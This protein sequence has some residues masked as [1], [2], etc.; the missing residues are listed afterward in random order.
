MRFALP[1]PLL[2]LLLVPRAQTVW[3]GRL[4]PKQLLGPWYVLAVASREKGFAQ[5]KVLRSVEGVVVSLTAENKLKMLASRSGQEGC[6][7]TVVELLK[8]GSGWV[9]ENPSLGVLEYRVLGT[10]FKDYAIVFTQLEFG[11][12]TFN[13]V[14]LYSRTKVASPEATKLFSKWSRDLGYLA[15]QQAKLQEDFTCAH[16][17]L[18][19][20]CPWGPGSGP[21]VSAMTVLGEEMAPKDVSML[22][23]STCDDVITGVVQSELTLTP[24]GVPDQITPNYRRESERDHIADFG[25]RGV[26][27]P[28]E[29]GET[30]KQPPRPKRTQPYPSSLTGTL[31]QRAERKVCCD[32][33]CS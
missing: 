5:G 2:V 31:C 14:E 4:D 17:V 21:V 15:Q 26:V 24:P 33:R 16:K 1:V 27:S 10:N 30:R 29:L 25:D 23:P 7:L 22:V 11:D 12:E 18:Q 6:S 3:L 20:S 9:F 8:Q 13:T 32:N 28:W 19:V